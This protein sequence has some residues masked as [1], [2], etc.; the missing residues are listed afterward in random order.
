MQALGFSFFLTK[1]QSLNIPTKNSTIIKMTYTGQ[2]DTLKV[3][4]RSKPSNDTNKNIELFK[5]R[6][7]AYDI[8][9][10]FLGFPFHLLN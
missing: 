5:Y 3:L 8:K 1:I 2:D 10:T 9:S 4:I 6:T 7:F